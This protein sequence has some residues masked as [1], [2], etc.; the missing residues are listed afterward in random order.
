VNASKRKGTAFESLVVGYLS[1]NGFDYA[2]RRA[3]AGTLDR[4]DIAGIPGVMIECKAEKAIDLAG[5]MDE[6]EVE[7]ANA[8]AQIGVAV[9]KRRNRP[10]D[11]AYVVMPLRQ[12]VRL[13]R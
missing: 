9:V 1:D 6:V 12:F 10:V 8:E 2:E 4:G 13:I 7:T 5:Y 3:L 11:Q